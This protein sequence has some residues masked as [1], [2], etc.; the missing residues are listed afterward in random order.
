MA[1]W[2]G[3]IWLHALVY[4]SHLFEPQFLFG[5]YSIIYNKRRVFYIVPETH[6]I[7]IMSPL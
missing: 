2:N 4:I 6:G 5:D 1:S 7:E 3:V